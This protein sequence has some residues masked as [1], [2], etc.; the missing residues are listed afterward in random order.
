MDVFKPELHESRQFRVS[1]LKF[2]VRFIVI[3]TATVVASCEGDPYAVETCNAGEGVSLPGDDTPYLGARDAPVRLTVFGDV[4]CP[5]TAEMILELTAFIDRL[6]AGG[7]SGLVE[8]QFR[9]FP[10]LRSRKL[11]RA[12]E[13]AHLAGN[14]AFW[15][16][17]WCLAT[18][19]GGDGD[20][21][22]ACAEQLDVDEAALIEDASSAVVGQAVSR[23]EAVAEAI[24]FP[25]APG[26]LLCGFWMP[27]DA[28]RIIDNVEALLPE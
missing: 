26:V 6:E 17:Y 15:Q 18:W 4:R 7:A 11:A 22:S 9:H 27:P 13:A 23:D 21:I 16:M 24:G 8:V 10:I 5:H 25:G 19:G 28:D 20:R 14:D 1:E 2:Q 12:A 3:L